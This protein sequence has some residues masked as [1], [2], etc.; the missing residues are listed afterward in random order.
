M[1]AVSLMIAMSQYLISVK[2]ERHEFDRWNRCSVL[3]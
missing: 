3:S 2:E 1:R